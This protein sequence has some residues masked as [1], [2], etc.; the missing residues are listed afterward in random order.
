MNSNVIISSILWII[1]I[2]IILIFLILLLPIKITTIC[3]HGKWK[4]DLKILFLSIDLSRIS[5]VGNDELKKKAVKK[6][7]SYRKNFEVNFEGIDSVYDFFCLLKMIMKTAKK[8]F[9]LAIKKLNVE[10]LT[11]KIAIGSENSAETAINYGRISSV[12]YPVAAW[13]VD[14][15]K[16]KSY[17]I[18]VSPNF[19]SAKTNFFFK[20]CAKTRIWNLLILVIEILKNL[21]IK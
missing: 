3:E 15:N 18:S 4:I 2:L 10:D 20:L 13:L 16:P 21:K 12:V 17:S 19:L 8:I 6:N 5:Q 11:F 7:G 14:L 9:I 1:L